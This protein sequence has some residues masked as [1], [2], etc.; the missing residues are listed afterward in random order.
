MQPANNHQPQYAQLFFYD[1]AYATEA[2]RRRNLELDGGLLQQFL[3]MLHVCNPFIQVYLTAR[4]RSQQAPEEDVRVMLNP[5]MRLVMKAGS[6]Q[7]RTNLP[8]SDEVAVIIPDE[9][10][11]RSFRDLLLA[12]RMAG[13][14]QPVFTRIKSHHPAYMPLH[15]VLLFPLGTYGFHW[16]LQLRSTMQA[17]VRTRVGQ[18]VFYRYRLHQ[19]QEEH[20]RIFLACR[21]YQQYVVDAWATCDQDKLKW[22][23]RNQ[24]TFRADLYQGLADTLLQ[25][26][27]DLANTGRRVILPSS[28]TGSDRFM[29]QL[30]LDMYV[31]PTRRESHSLWPVRDA[32]IPQS[33]KRPLH[34][35]RIRRSLLVTLAHCGSA[36]RRTQTRPRMQRSSI[37]LVCRDLI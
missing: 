3:N 37:G 4:E 25:S 7:R 35:N 20:P 28:H 36:Y 8:T 14:E 13:E 34:E 1:P 31:A 30:F 21:L 5:Q 12:K 33:C 2:C 10:G 16:A 9:Y 15:Y 6:D 23:Q 18:R 19:H 17:R 24:E 29:M 22:I 32:G 26:D 27:V 11:E